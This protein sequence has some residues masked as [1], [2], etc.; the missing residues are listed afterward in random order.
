MAGRHSHSAMKA[1]GACTSTVAVYVDIRSSTLWYEHFFLVHL[2][3][4]EDFLGAKRGKSLLIVSTPRLFNRKTLGAV[5]QRQKTTSWLGLQRQPLLCR[6]RLPHRRRHGRH[7]YRT[8][9]RPPLLP[10]SRGSR[11]RRRLAAAVQACIRT[12]SGTRE[13]LARRAPSH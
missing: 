12:H 11:S 7:R 5:N 13:T 2:H 10:T 4:T 9:R 6:G 3:E 1:E 8:P